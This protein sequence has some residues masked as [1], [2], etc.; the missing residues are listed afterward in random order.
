MKMVDREEMK[1][2]ELERRKLI[3]ISIPQI[4]GFWVAAHQGWGK[5]FI[6]VARI[7]WDATYLNKEKIKEKMY[8]IL[9][10]LQAITKEDIQS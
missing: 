5:I 4:S 7:Q 6:V 1:K 8:G 10:R 2:D 3:I 9:E